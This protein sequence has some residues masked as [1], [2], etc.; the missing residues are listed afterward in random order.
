[1]W[2]AEGPGLPSQTVMNISADLL[3][4]S[5]HSF[6]L[7]ASIALVASS[8]PRHRERYFSLR[9]MCRRRVL[10]RV[11]VLER[12]RERE[13]IEMYGATVWRHGSPQWSGLSGLSLV[14]DSL[15]E[16]HSPSNCSLTSTPLLFSHSPTQNTHSL[17]H[18]IVYL[19]LWELSNVWPSPLH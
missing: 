5:L 19:S 3:K 16:R 4:C 13:S 14:N 8:V 7:S 11:C 15:S 10:M 2:G 18:T 6:F 12:E 1:M 9:M 17:T